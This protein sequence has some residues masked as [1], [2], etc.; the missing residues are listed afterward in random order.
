MFVRLEQERNRKQIRSDC[1]E[2]DVRR[3]KRLKPLEE[4][5][6]RHIAVCMCDSCGREFRIYD[7]V[8]EKSQRKYHFCS[9]KC[10]GVAQKSGGVLFNPNTAL[11]RP[12]VLQR[13]KISSHTLEAEERRS[14]SLK[15]YH[16]N[17]PSDWQ[18]PGNTPE[19]CAK[20]HQTMKANGTYRKSS[21]EDALYVYLCDKHGVE[22]IVRNALV[23]NRWPIDFYVKSI[24]TYVQLDG[25]Y[26]HGL[27]RPIEVISEHRTKRD[28]Q[29]HKKW[30]TDREQDRWF[31][32]QGLNLI[33]LTDVQFYKG[34]RP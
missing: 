14:V 30:L 28:A 4:L 33:R 16:A 34:F 15:A 18:N 6:P 10:K 2:D 29:I 23:N 22:Q 11:I 7:H 1:I 5:K 31:R 27:D 8:A 20:R 17:K 12:D 26:W 25:V 21:V 19:A 13:L 3:Q 24:D 32:E 9:R